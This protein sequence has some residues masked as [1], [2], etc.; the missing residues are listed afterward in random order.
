MLEY[1]VNINL[2]SYTDGKR[3]A[4]NPE[5]RAH[6]STIWDFFSVSRAVGSLVSWTSMRNRSLLQKGCSVQLLNPQTYS[7]TMWLLQS[8]LQELFGSFVGANMYCQTYIT[9]LVQ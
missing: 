3:L 9:I 4:H 1:S 5:G 7:D 8:I 6:A 2:T